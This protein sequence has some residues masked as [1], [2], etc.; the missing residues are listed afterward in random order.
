MAITNDLLYNR[1]AQLGLSIPHA[2]TVVGCGGIGAWV[3][4]LGAM[5][6]ISNIYLFDPDD[7]EEHNRNRLPFCQGSLNQKKVDIVRNYILNIRPDAV[8]VAIPE[9]LEGLLLNIQMS[10]S[11]FIVDCTDSPK[12]QFTIY[13]ACKEHSI[14]YVRAGYD[15]T[16]MTVTSNVSGWIK[17]DVVEEAYTVNP[18]WVVPAVTVAA[19]AIGKMEKYFNQEISTDVGEIGIPVLQHNKRL[20]ARCATDTGSPLVSTASSRYGRRR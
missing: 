6:G 4:I 19:L 5:S 8:V 3:A 11:T 9:R 13:K 18:S 14:G 7:I 1:Q 10:V 17:T 15:G 20:T 2:I 16:H 12:S